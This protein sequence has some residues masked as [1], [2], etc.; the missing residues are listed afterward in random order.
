MLK[1]GQAGEKETSCH[2]VSGMGVG[3][4]MHV[5]ALEACVLYM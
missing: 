5:H 1:V 2:A 3:R 4:G